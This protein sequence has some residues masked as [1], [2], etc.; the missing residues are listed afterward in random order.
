MPTV[1]SCSS[2]NYKISLGWVHYHEFS[3][4][5]GSQ[6]LLV[7]AACGTP[8][9]IHMALTPDLQDE[10]HKAAN[11]LVDDVGP[12]PQEVKRVLRAETGLNRHQA[13]AVIESLPGVFIS[14]RSRTD[15]QIILEKLVRAGANG[16]IE[17]THEIYYQKDALFVL[18]TGDNAN[19]QPCEIVGDRKNLTGQFELK[20]QICA[21][22][23]AQGTLSAEL[24]ISENNVGVCPSCQQST[25]TVAGSWKT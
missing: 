17:T 21:V 2:C 3:S 14:G 4:G 5:Y 19:W 24:A 11:I 15:A 25:L 8:H 1:Y 16:H 13:S 7:C 23:H 20:E 10:M 12:L 22:C 18:I 9:A 6:M